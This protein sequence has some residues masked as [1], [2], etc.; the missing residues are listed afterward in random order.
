[1][2]AN[3]SK[4]IDPPR[5][6]YE[7]DSMTAKMIGRQAK[8]KMSIS[9]WRCNILPLNSFSELLKV[10]KVNKHSITQMIDPESL[11]LTGEI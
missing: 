2:V 3:V 4:A 1:M 11:F 10:N 9:L 7:I 6:P 5:F 8:V